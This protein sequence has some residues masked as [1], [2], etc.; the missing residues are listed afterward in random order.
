[1][2][3]FARS[4]KTARWRPTHGSILDLAERAGISTIASCR[5]G[6]C[7]TCSAKILSGSVDYAE[8]PGHEVPP[9]EALIC[10]STPHPGVHLED[11]LDREGVS[12]DL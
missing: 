7:A 11:S 9:G 5:V 3:T 4:G 8:P 12:L 6:S 10:C 1:M 2:V